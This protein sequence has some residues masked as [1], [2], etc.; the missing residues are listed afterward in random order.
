MTRY[1]VSLCILTPPLAVDCD[2]QIKTRFR[3]IITVLSFFRQTKLLEIISI[4]CA[5][6]LQYVPC[7]QIVPDVLLSRVLHFDLITWF[8]TIFLLF[9][10]FLDDWIT[11]FIKFN[12]TS[13]HSFGK[14]FLSWSILIEKEYAKFTSW[15]FQYMLVWDIFFFQ[16]GGLNAMLGYL[17][18]YLVAF[19]LHKLL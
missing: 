16:D 7:F 14:W 19:A 17:V 12:L 3:S 15:P 9:V 13:Q 8:I 1:I 2:W 5:N 18:L 11:Q 10:Y 6:T 4:L